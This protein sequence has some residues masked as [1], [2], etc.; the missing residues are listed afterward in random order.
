VS[1]YLLRARAR[2]DIREIALY[3]QQTWGVEQ[4][5][6]YIDGLFHFFGVLAEN[7]GLGIARDD[8]AP[9]LRSLRHG[10]HLAIY[11]PARGGVEI[12]RV[13]HVSRDVR[14]HVD[15]DEP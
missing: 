11:L 14:L 13:L 12:V 8:I 10:R 3:T 15:T 5:D 7:P 2:E 9:G 4:R 6:R 1:G